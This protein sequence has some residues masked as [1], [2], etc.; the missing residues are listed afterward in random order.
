MRAQPLW[1]AL[2]T[3]Q[4]AFISPR[5]CL[6]DD[7]YRL[8][9][10]EDAWRCWCWQVFYVGSRGAEAT[11]CCCRSLSLSGMAIK[12]RSELSSGR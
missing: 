11:L 6:S 9:D 12:A 5:E 3:S 1:V 4:M 8:G 2:A 7:G 10:E